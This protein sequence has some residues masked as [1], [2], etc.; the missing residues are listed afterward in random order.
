[1]AQSSCFL[2]VNWLTPVKI[3]T[4]AVTGTSGYAQL[5]YVTQRLDF[6]PAQA[7]LETRSF[8]DVEA[9]SEQEPERLDFP[10]EE[11]LARELVEFLKAARRRAGRHR[12][13]AGREADDGGGRQAGR[14]RRAPGLL[15]L[16]RRLLVTGAGGSAAANFVH[17]LRM[18]S[19]DF[20]LVGTDSDRYLL[21][22]AD[23]DVRYLVPRADDPSYLAEL[24]AVIETEQIDLVHPQPDPEVLALSAVRDELGARTFLPQHET[25]VLCQDKAASAQAI[26]AAGLPSPDARSGTSEEELRAATAEILEAHGKAWVRARRGAGARASLPVT[27]PEQAVAWL[28]YWADVRGLTAED[29]MVS[30]FLS[31]REFAFQSLW[32]DGRLLVSAARERLAYLFGHVAPSGQTST[33]SVARTVH[34]Q[35]VNELAAAIVRAVDPAATGVFCVDL[36]EDA[37]G[38]PLVTEI[39]AG[40]FFTTSNFLAAAGVNMP[41]HYVRLALGEP[42]EELPSFNAAEADLYWIRMIDMGFKL[43]REGEWTSRPSS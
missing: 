43:V 28:Q 4:L 19:E 3:R 29:F 41:Y 34:R 22:L 7:N 10:H 20:H 2:Q 18:T 14:G 42:V 12:A 5:E 33:P 36:K 35:D 24:R 13:S 1:M 40:R 16:V 15:V 6:Y 23:L 37:D 21:E 30:Q 32:L 27:A 26:A 9:F 25:I 31:G 38:R 39:N 17:S 8:A 11:P